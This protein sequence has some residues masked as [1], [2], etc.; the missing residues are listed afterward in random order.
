MIEIKD[1]DVFYKNIHALREISISIPK[2]KIIGLIGGNGAGKS[3]MMKAI[4]G[5]VPKKSGEIIFED[6]KITDMDSASISRL[7]ISTVPEGR[8]LFG[9]MTV[10]D[11]M[12]LGAYLRFKKEKKKEIQK[13]MDEIFNLFPRLGERINQLAGTLSGGEQQM[14]AIARALMGR[15]KVIL[16][17]EPSTGL[18]PL[19]VKEIFKVIRLLKSK[20]NTILLIEQNA[21]M[22]LKISDYA[23]VMESGRFVLEGNAK[24][25]LEDESVKKSYLGV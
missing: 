24:D 23:Y 3:T 15:P 7:G 12:N 8:R 4:T 5:L 9:S 10:E 21:R 22:A 1:I 6:R 11:N 2:G 17:D 13:D 19:I 25:L 20:G 18:A 14:L 16:M